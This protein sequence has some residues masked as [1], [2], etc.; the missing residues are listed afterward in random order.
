MY[1]GGL[2]A[3]AEI[4]TVQ[5]TFGAYLQNG[6]VVVIVVLR[7]VFWMYGVLED[8]S[9]L[10]PYGQDVGAGKHGEVFRNPV[11]HDTTMFMY[12]TN[13]QAACVVV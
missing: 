12:V 9:P 4:H 7:I 6:D 1:L 3:P 5:I 8:P 13:Q 11:T 2:Q 10:T